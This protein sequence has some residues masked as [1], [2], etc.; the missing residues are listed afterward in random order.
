MI[1]LITRVMLETHT[2]K[3]THCAY[4]SAL[5]W[6]STFSSTRGGLV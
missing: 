3:F 4:M 2:P 6:I 1:L 5:Y